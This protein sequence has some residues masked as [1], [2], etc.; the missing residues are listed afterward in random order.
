MTRISHPGPFRKRHA[1]TTFLRVPDHSW[2][3][4]KHGSLTE[5]RYRRLSIVGLEPPCPVVCYRTGGTNQDY[6]S[7]VM[8]LEEVWREPLGA[9]SQDSLDRLG[10]T[11]PEF[12]RDWVE[13]R[14]KGF[15]PLLEFNVFRVR[16]FERA[17]LEPL[18][19]RLIER[20]YGAFLP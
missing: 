12:R 4:V 6:D 8:V 13:R 16:Q 17:D 1:W 18:G 19:A 10:M 14:G 9:I 5:F 7:R 2:L 3:E 20:L 15:E 11:F